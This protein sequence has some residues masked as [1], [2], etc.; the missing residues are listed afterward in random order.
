MRWR[1]LICYTYPSLPLFQSN[2][3][4]SPPFQFPS[5]LTSLSRRFGVFSGPGI[6]SLLLLLLAHKIAFIGNETITPLKLID[7]GFSKEQLALT[8]LI[9]FPSQLVLGVLAARWSGGSQPLRPWLLAQHF[10][11]LMGLVGMGWWLRCRLSVSA[12]SPLLLPCLSWFSIPFCP[13]FFF[14][15]LVPP[16]HV[17]WFPSCAGWVRL[18]LVAYG[19]ATINFPTCYPLSSV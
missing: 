15:S 19:P 6:R 5:A 18:G 13:S 17:D 8:A 1:P 12:C 4:H 11:L 14:R 7:L 3:H 2:H 10:R 9:D 16:W